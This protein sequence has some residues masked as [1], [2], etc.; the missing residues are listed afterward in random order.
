MG[1]KVL[2]TKVKVYIHNIVNETVM[3]KV[4]FKGQSNY[5]YNRI[6]KYFRLQVT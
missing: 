6:S 2:M 5:I 1:Y 3:S 4:L